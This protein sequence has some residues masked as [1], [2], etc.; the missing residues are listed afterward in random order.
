M[1]ATPAGRDRLRELLDAVL[2]EDHRSLQDMAR[3]AHSSPFHFARLLRDQTGE[4]P[5]ALRRRVVLER[6]AWQL[7]HGATVHDAAEAAGYDSVDG[8][9]RAFR[10]AYGHPPA[11]TPQASTGQV[12]SATA[13]WLSAPN[14]IHFHPPSS[15]WVSDRPAPGGGEVLRLMVAHDLDDTRALLRHAATIPADLRHADGLPADGVLPWDGPERS[16]ADVLSH[17]VHTRAVWLAA[18]RGEDMPAQADHDPVALLALHDRNAAAWLATLRDIEQRDAWGD[19]L[20]DALCDPPETFVLA[21]VVAHV[22]TFAAARRQLARQ[23]MAA[24]GHP[25]PDLGDPLL[26]MREQ[27]PDTPTGGATP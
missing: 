20:V 22:L 1:S 25:I 23:L 17:L 24:A 7:A 13:H 3:G 12:H 4:P 16:L 18:I 11:D 9:S 6:A 5:V 10:R 2:D 19:L 15:L 14:G 21:G 8:F 27:G 26:W